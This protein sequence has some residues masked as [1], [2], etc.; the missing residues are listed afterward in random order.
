MMVSIRFAA[1][2]LVAACSI[3]V[4]SVASA[5]CSSDSPAGSVGNAA[6]GGL[7]CIPGATQACLGPGACKGAQ[8]CRAEGMS[9]G[10]C[11]CGNGDGGSASSGGAGGAGGATGGGGQTTGG[12]G[13]SGGSGGCTTDQDCGGAT[14]FCGG[15]I[16]VQCLDA[17]H[18]SDAQCKL[19]ACQPLASQDRVLWLRG[20]DLAGMQNGALVA[21]W[22][23]QSP[24]MN[25]AV[26]SGT[27]R[28]SVVLGAFGAHPGVA[29]DGIDDQLTLTANPSASELTIVALVRASSN[30][31]LI[32]TGSSSPGFLQSYGCGVVIS[33]MRP[34]LKSVDDSVGVQLT[35]PANHLIADHPTVIAATL[36]ASGAELSLAGLAHATATDLP[37]HYAYS[38]ATL[39]ASD[40]SASDAAADPFAGVIGELLVYQ[41]KLSTLE[42]A[43]V[44]KYLTEKHQLSAPPPFDTL[45]ADATLFYK[46]HESGDGQRADIKSGLGLTPWEKTGPNSYD[47]NGA[48]TTPVPAVVGDGQHVMGAQGYHFSRPDAGALNHAGGSFTWA[49]WVSIDALDPNDPYNDDQAFVAKWNVPPNPT[50]MEYLVLFKRATEK[51]TFAVS[52]NGS[53]LGAEVVSPAVVA[54]GVFYLLEAWHDAEAG[55]IGLRVSEPNSLGSPV[56][57]MWGGGVFDSTAD[58]NVGAFNTCKDSHL[59]GIVDAVGYWPRVLTDVERQKLHTGIELL[60]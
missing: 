8:V 18:C 31:H 54:P 26:A 38:R 58:L 22:D 7:L 2:V 55:T 41:R 51:W 37:N 39:G 48:G 33:D 25:H 28:P 60:P 32:G 9:F 45:N 4:L 16:C 23:D 35:T 13:G 17:S 5:G 10:T 50:H 1:A 42:L 30:G 12:S 19:G 15:A 40:G 21:Q 52:G 14:P 44:T 3:V 6:G 46:M 34:M 36:G 47:Q 11:D 27:R 57:A 49:G 56:T 24:E 29:F 20:S 59:Q 43:E 53:Q